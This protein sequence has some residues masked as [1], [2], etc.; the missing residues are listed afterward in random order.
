MERFP[1]FFFFWQVA[2]VTPT[3]GGQC[4]NIAGRF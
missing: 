4:G 1:F 3:L 2:T